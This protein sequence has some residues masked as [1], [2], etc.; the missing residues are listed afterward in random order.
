[1]SLDATAA[2]PSDVARGLTDVRFL[3]G[4]LDSRE[5]DLARRQ[6]ELADTIGAAPAADV[7]GRSGKTSR[8]KAEQI[9]ARA[10]ALTD[11]P[12]LAQ[13]LADGAISADHADAFASVAGGAATTRFASGSSTTKQI[14]QPTRLGAPPNSSD[15]D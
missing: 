14:S 3:R 7:L 1:V 8:R 2:G 4:W 11:A 9:A 15:V 6:A 12:A 10:A 13:G 5:I